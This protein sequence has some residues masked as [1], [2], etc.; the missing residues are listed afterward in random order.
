MR[1]KEQAFKF[2]A[3]AR[4]GTK[5]YFA[6]FWHVLK[7]YNSDIREAVLTRK[8]AG[9]LGP[10]VFFGITTAIAAFAV[11]KL[12]RYQVK[13]IDLQPKW[14]L[15][16]F[17]LEI[18]NVNLKNTCVDFINALLMAIVVYGIANIFRQKI[19]LRRCLSAFLY[20][21]A[22]YIVAIAVATLVQLNF[23]TA[24]DQV[25]AQNSQYNFGEGRS[26]WINT[27]ADNFAFSGDQLK[28]P[29][30]SFLTSY[31][32]QR[33]Y[34][35]P[36]VFP[37]FH[38]SGL[39]INYHSNWHE[40]SVVLI[41]LDF[42]VALAAYILRLRLL[43]SILIVATCSLFGF[44][45]DAAVSRATGK[46]GTLFYA[47]ARMT[48]SVVPQQAF[49]YSPTYFDNFP[50]KTADL[51][52]IDY[53]SCKKARYPSNHAFKDGK[54]YVSG[55]AISFEMTGVDCTTVSRSLMDYIF[56]EYEIVRIVATEGQTVEVSRRGEIKVDGEAIAVEASKREETFY[57]EAP[58]SLAEGTAT[59]G[60]KLTMQQLL[61]LVRIPVSGFRYEYAY[62]RWQLPHEPAVA[63]YAWECSQCDDTSVVEGGTI[64][65]APD[66]IFVMFDGVSRPRF[67]HIR[68]DQVIGHPF[69]KAEKR[70]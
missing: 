45:L 20:A 59:A 62:Y 51:A 14:W 10:L 17:D 11:D 49:R 48:P 26:A 34:Y 47:S 33:F 29:R 43:V 23:F 63:T 58:R 21:Y 46:H 42:K 64:T 54:G 32:L 18:F 30:P 5:R 37:L 24:A 25:P 38:V 6:T 53:S 55:Y 8:F 1:I 36:A 44:Y 39:A 68:A 16:P 3:K 52:L 4:N 9:A 67:M 28:I 15:S 12:S 7:P 60:D 50:A 56:P 57:Y 65:V 35:M 13:V 40:L 70:W 31:D 66:T 27:G 19:S 22:I 41:L 2:A 69:V 61:D